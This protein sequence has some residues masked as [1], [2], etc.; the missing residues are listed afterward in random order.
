MEF[1]RNFAV[2]WRDVLPPYN[3]YYIRQYFA[4]NGR[5]SIPTTPYTVTPQKTV[6]L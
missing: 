2:F 1:V 3:I 6:I 4:P 5:Q